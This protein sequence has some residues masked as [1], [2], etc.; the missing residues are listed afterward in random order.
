MRNFIKRTCI[1]LLIFLVI[2]ELI[3]R[4]IIDPYYYY[5]IDTY[6][7]KQEKTSLNEIFKYD[8][9]ESVDYLFIGSSRV[10]A[11]INPSIFTQEDPGKKAVVAGRGYMTA[12]IHYQ[13]LKN[14]LSIN[15]DFLK[16]TSVLIEYPGS[17]VYTNPFSQ[18]E[19]TVYEPL[20]AKD[21]AMPHLLL[22]HIN[23]HSLFAFIKAS[24][25][26]LKVKVDFAAQYFFAS[27][28]SSIFVKEKFHKLNNY[29]L[30]KE[31]KQNLATEGGI[32]ND[33]ISEGMQQVIEYAEIQKDR[34][35]KNAPL[36]FSD[37]DN[38]S[39][40]RFNKLIKDS[41][42][43]LFLYKMPLSSIQESA[44]K[45]EKALYNKSVFEEW[46][47]VNQIDVLYN[48]RFSYDDTDFPDT[49]HLSMSRR[50][51]FS[52]ILFD[53]IKDCQKQEE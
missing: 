33:N 22:P 9:N 3:S 10:P 34:I 31:T 7:F 43:K 39:L 30:F 29:Y 2:L 36:E 38:S 14:R 13:A 32:R 28:R 51:E 17:G 5:S 23:F 41:G 40:A 35:E 47:A 52:R 27:Y 20:L 1:T 8:I 44:Y 50:D 18:D 24:N 19:L 6:R 15:P 26:S 16:G 53:E 4:L 42:G 49:W 46:I 11:T 12:G 25:N 21:K 48:E 45:S 37:L